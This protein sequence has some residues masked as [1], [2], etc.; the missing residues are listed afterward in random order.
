MIFGQKEAFLRVLADTAEDQIFVINRDDL[1][2]FV[3]RAGARQLGATPEQLI[4]RKRTEVFP[5]AVAERQQLGLKRVFETGKALYVEGPTPYSGGEVWLS[6][7]LTPVPGPD[8]SVD[9]VLGV[10]RDL[11]DQKRAQD[12]LR[13][14]EERLRVV[15]SNVP[16]LLWAIDADGIITFCSG[17]ALDASPLASETLVGRPFADIPIAPFPDLIA[18]A[19]RALTGEETNDQIEIGNLTYETWSD[20]MRDARGTVVGATGVVVDI[21]ERRRV[22]AELLTGQKL[23]AIG[24]LAGGIAHDFNNHLT[25]ILGYVEMML[26]RTATETPAASDLRDVQQ[27]AERAAGLVQR[28]L[29]F[30]RR[31][32]LQPR[33]LNLNTLIEGLQPMLER[34]IG[35]G[36][37]IDAALTPDLLA[38]TGDVAELEQVI[39][40]LALNARDAMPAGG[41]L[42]ITTQNVDGIDRR[43]GSM[44][45][46]PYVL[47][48]IRDTGAGMDAHV[49]EHVFEPFFTTKP[50]GQGTGLGLSTVYGIIKQ[51]DGFIWLDS[52]IGQGSAFHV[53]LPASPA[54]AMADA[55]APAPTIETLSG[56]RVTVLLVEDEPTVRRFARRALELHGF[57]VVEAS[58]PEEAL[59][60]AA[61]NTQLSLLLTDVV[62]P[63]MNGREL[64]DQ[65]RAVWPDLPVLYMSGYP[66]SLVLRDG[67]LDPSMRL[68][69]KPFTTLELIASVHEALATPGA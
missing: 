33:S 30:G 65:L 35:A 46:G 51:L 68:I 67:L 18:Q 42:T 26:G 28:L 45:P 61:E 20:P 14:S 49:K 8:G 47:M 22:Q 11:T 59:V 23:E 17:R 43:H 21:T 13:A 36:I 32:V 66:S 52:T 7:W 37:L 2:E 1:I 16:L 44:T 63:R 69:S 48:T 9:A 5:P 31:Q 62:M 40:N 38:V 25:A 24:R 39:M 12:A 64:A 27:A 4:G 54:V 10:S 6:T 41:T 57:A 50:E 60:L 58:S 19:R 3:N 15:I 34:L 55:S 29:A 56:R 53:Y